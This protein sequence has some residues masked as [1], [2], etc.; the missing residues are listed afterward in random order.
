MKRNKPM[1]I[2]HSKV[3][4]VTLKL[5]P[6]N[7]YCDF[8]KIDS[9]CIRNAVSLSRHGIIYTAMDQNN[10]WNSSIWCLSEVKLN[11]QKY[12]TKRKRNT[13]KNKKFYWFQKRRM[14]LEIDV[15]HVFVLVY[16]L[17]AHYTLRNG[18]WLWLEM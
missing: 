14:P 18:A 2:S 13:K 15:V 11:K 17:C 10:K 1:R 7:Y 6:R 9:I 5:S 16:A 12:L 4:L 8:G 3:K